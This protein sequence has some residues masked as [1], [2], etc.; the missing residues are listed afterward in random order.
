[1]SKQDASYE[2]RDGKQNMR[3]HTHDGSAPKEGRPVIF[4]YHGGGWV[5]ADSDT[6]EVSILALASKTNAIVFAGL[7][8]N[9]ARSGLRHGGRGPPRRQTRG[10]GVGGPEPYA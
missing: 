4:Y 7:G 2:T 3:I 8:G 1:M 9:V 10:D 6:Y 5:I